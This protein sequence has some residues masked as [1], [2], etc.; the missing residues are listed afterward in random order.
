MPA[1]VSEKK[2][3]EKTTWEKLQLPYDPDCVS[4]KVI[5]MLTLYGA[6]ILVLSN[7][8][9]VPEA[10]KA[11]KFAMGLFGLGLLGTGTM[12]LFV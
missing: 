2:E 8:K 6:G 1:E 10:N 5:G 3:I 7:V 12:R 9:R 4:C 11:G